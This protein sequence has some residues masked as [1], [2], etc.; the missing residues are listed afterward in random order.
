MDM[1]TIPFPSLSLSLSL[2]LSH[3]HTHTHKAG[4]WTSGSG[5]AFGISSCAVLSP[6]NLA[7]TTHTHMQVDVTRQRLA[8]L[9]RDFNTELISNLLPIDRSIF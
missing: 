7:D 1:D 3:T 9:V 8:Q 4:I 2:S 6:T 5:R